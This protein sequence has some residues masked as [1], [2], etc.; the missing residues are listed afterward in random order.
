MSSNKSFPLLSYLSQTIC[1][2]NR[3]I[4]H[5]NPENKP[6]FFSWSLEAGGEEGGRKHKERKVTESEW[7]N[8]SQL[9]LQIGL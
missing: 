6:L 9:R 1:H 3:K 5:T 7:K 8:R 4:T 2:S